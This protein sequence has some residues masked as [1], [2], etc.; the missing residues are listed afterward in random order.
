MGDSF[1]YPMNCFI[2]C[3]SKARKYMAYKLLKVN[4]AVLINPQDRRKPQ[5]ANNLMQRIVLIDHTF[6]FGKEHCGVDFQ[7]VLFELRSTR[8]TQYLD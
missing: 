5:L 3:F 6:S 2:V 4:W 1:R 7:F 8:Y